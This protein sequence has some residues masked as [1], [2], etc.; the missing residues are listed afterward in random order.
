MRV[1]IHQLGKSRGIIIPG[2]FLAQLGLEKQADMAIEGHALVIRKTSAKPRAGWAAASR[3]IAEVR[4]DRLVLG[5][6]SN[7]EDEQAIW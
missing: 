5:E 3:E 4:D 1:T 6:F 7:R 2:E